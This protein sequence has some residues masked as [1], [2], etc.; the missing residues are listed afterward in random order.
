MSQHVRTH[1]AH[2]AV[3]KTLIH[4]KQSTLQTKSTINENTKNATKFYCHHCAHRGCHCCGCI[5]IAIVI[6]IVI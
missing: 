1:H 5:A 4:V 6:A 2:T 3:D